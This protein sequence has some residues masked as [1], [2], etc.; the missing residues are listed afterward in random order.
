[1]RRKNKTSGPVVAGYDYS[2]KEAREITVGQLFARAK[3][4]R[5]VVEEEWKVYN[6]YYNFVHSASMETAG[7]ADEQGDRK[8]VV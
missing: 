7:Y 5:S 2:T 1:M 8:S 6:S 3:S 4:A